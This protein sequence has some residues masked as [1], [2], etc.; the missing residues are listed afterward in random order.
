MKHGN[1]THTMQ[2]GNVRKK[3]VTVTM[4]NTKITLKSV[5]KNCIVRR[6]AEWE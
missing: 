2:R 3:M 6:L 4:K 5:L 1:K